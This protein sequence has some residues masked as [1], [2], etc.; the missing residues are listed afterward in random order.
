MTSHPSENFTPQMIFGN[1]LW[2]LAEEWRLAAARL[3]LA[4]GF[5]P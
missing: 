5:P 3:A 4:R 2:T 1:W